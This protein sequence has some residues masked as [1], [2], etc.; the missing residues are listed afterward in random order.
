MPD[1]VL[2][3]CSRRF[4]FFHGGILERRHRLLTENSPANVKR[5]EF[6]R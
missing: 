6:R 3:V 4:V 2:R 5:M 1:Y